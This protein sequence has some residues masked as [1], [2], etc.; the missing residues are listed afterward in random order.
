MYIQRGE[1]LRKAKKKGKKSKY[2]EHMHRRKID[3][4]EGK[5]IEVQHRRRKRNLSTT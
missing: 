5:N 1:P 4:V 2:E 3:C